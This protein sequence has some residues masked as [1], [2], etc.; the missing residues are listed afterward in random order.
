MEKRAMTSLRQMHLI[1]LAKCQEY[2]INPRLRT[3][4]VAGLLRPRAADRRV[5][6]KSS[7]AKTA[8]AYFAAAG[9]NVG[10]VT[11][12]LIQFAV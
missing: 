9:T 6:K 11:L 5:A 3:R 7:E 10:Y 4:A 2:R 12:G 8:V 1:A